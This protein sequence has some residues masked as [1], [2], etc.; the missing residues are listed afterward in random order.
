MILGRKKASSGAP[1]RVAPFRRS[2]TRVLEVDLPKISTPR[3][4][5]KKTGYHYQEE[6]VPPPPKRLK[7]ENRKDLQK[8]RSQERAVS[9]I[10]EFDPDTQRLVLPSKIG[11]KPDVNTM[12]CGQTMFGRRA[13]DILSLLEDE[14]TDSALV[15]LQRSLVTTMV[16][17]LPVVEHAV[18]ASRGQ[19]GIQNLNMCVSQI[20][21]M[22]ADIQATKDRGLLGEQIADRILRPT[23]LNVAVQSRSALET[24]A[25][26]VRPYMRDEDYKAWYSQHVISMMKSL[27]DVLQM[28]FL[29]MKNSVLKAT[30]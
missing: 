3:P 27:S 16:D 14:Q 26:S 15:V 5:A 17:L 7:V 30:G 24:L 21:E 18:R 6:E 29:D 2:D 22:M 11:A 25:M 13:D 19:R 20:R 8:E 23:V 28:S 10:D 4:S 12:R 1:E 9:R